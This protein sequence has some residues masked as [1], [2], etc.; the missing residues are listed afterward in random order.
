MCTFH[1]NLSPTSKRRELK[2]HDSCSGRAV[3]TAKG[4]IYF[5]S[6]YVFIAQFITLACFRCSHYLHYSPCWSR[7]HKTYESMNMQQWALMKNHSSV[8][9]KGISVQVINTS[10]V[11]HHLY[12]VR[13]RS[14]TPNNWFYFCPLSF[15]SCIYLISLFERALHVHSGRQV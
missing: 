7:V 6:V 2:V 1:C 3:V 8:S 13:S 12:R 5:V 15:F 14:R 9:D 11:L 10:S 4:F